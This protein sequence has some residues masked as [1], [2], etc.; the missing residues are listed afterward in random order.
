[1]KWK[2]SLTGSMKYVYM[3]AEGQFKSASDAEKFEMV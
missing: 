1:M 3:S 2:D